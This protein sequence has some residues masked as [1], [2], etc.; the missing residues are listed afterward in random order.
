MV[1]DTRFNIKTNNKLPISE[2]IL[3]NVLY[4]E[5][6]FPSTFYRFSELFSPEVHICPA[7]SAIFPAITFYDANIFPIKPN[8][9]VLILLMEIMHFS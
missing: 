3:C 5:N 2:F 4:K 1:Y 9:F 6:H 7:N 8:F